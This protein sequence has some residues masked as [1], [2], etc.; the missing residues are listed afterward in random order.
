MLTVFNAEIANMQ[1]AGATIVDVS[2]D[3]SS[4]SEDEVTLLL[5]EFKDDIDN[6]PRG[7]SRFPASP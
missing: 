1:G 7:P 6:V 4:W 2:L 5:Y 3:A